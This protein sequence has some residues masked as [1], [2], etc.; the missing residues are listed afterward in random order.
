MKLSFFQDKVKV[1]KNAR[2][3]LE[4]E[5]FYITDDLT[6]VDLG[7]KRK[8]KNQVSELFQQGTRLHFSGGCWRG[9]NGKPFN[10][11]HFIC[12]IIL[13]SPF[14][15]RKIYI[16][17]HIHVMPLQDIARI[18]ILLRRCRLFSSGKL[19]CFCVRL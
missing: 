1:M 11:H 13:N 10:F 7:E 19:V 9:S 16:Y 4:R 3:A 14:D 2:R 5:N 6:K 18:W 12:F 8:W 15:E 17:L